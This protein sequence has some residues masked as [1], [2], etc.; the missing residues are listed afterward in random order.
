MPIYF[1]VL[2]FIL[3]DHISKFMIEHTMELG[4][5]IPIIKGV[6]HLTYILNPGAAFGILENQRL[7]FILIAVFMVLMV[8]YLYPRIPQKFK[9]MRMGVALLLS[10]AIGNLIDRIKT[11]L[12]VDF[13]DFRI[14]PIFNIADICIVLGV[15]MII[16]AML[17]A[18]KK[19]KGENN[20]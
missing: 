15:G 6:F 10:G 3:L 19:L 1:F 14:W 8:G 2:C 5:S 20:E 16:Y 11:G 13:F 9:V 18:E 4:A 12:V 17:C 7:F